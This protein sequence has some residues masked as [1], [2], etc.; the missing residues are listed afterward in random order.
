MISCLTLR[1]FGFRSCWLTPVGFLLHL[2]QKRSSRN[3]DLIFIHLCNYGVCT[4][5]PVWSTVSDLF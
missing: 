2:P 1:A 5:T 3:A 4:Y